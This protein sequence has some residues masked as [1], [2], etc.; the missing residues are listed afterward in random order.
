M[1]TIATVGSGKYTYEM[2]TDW[3]KLPEGQAMPAAA[4]Y[5]DSKDRVYCFN[6]N[7]DHPIQ[8]FD[9]EG[10]YLNSWGAGIFAFPHAI[11]LDKDDDVWVVERNHGQ[12]MKFTNDGKLLQ[13][14]GQKGFRSD[15]GADNTDFGSNGW[16]LVT[17][18]GD[19]FNMPAGI[20]VNDAGE[21]FIA[22]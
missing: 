15:T 21:I 2:H 20:A 9:R 14:I 7:L 5:G 4:V 6:R 11:I 18:G 22:D 12:I 17:H 16:K 19:P 8:I 13:T 1:T 3:A 10:N